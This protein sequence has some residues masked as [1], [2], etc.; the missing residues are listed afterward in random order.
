MIAGSIRR[1]KPFPGDVEIV[2]E[3]LFAGQS[4]M[5][6]GMSNPINQ[7]DEHCQSL[8]Y[9]GALEKRLDVKRRPRWGQRTKLALFFYQGKPVKADLFSVLKPA[10]WSVILAIRTGSG[11]F[12]KRLVQHA[13]TVGRKVAGGQVWNLSGVENELRWR[14][15]AQPSDKFV[16]E[17]ERLGL[18]VV[19]TPTEEAYFEALQVPCWPPE[20]RTE[21][22]LRSF[23]AVRARG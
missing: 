16:K 13:H 7:F 20:E 11:A 6:G 18:T 14:L 3:P 1:K 15:S 8:L 10:S 5:F 22:R 21:Q 4:S 9:A 19:P 2:L 12:N 23:L 17:A